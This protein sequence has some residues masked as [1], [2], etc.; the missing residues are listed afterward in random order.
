MKT[1]T[2]EQTP[3]A[4]KKRSVLI[5]RIVGLVALVGAAALLWNNLPLLG[6]VAGAVLLLAV[7]GFYLVEARY[8]KA[9]ERA[10]AR[11]VR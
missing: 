8:A 2:S 4:E 7:T 1:G 5:I 10:L 3:L 9:L 11:S 6:E